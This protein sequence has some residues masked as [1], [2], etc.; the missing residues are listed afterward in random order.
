MNFSL[1]FQTLEVNQ[2]PGKKISIVPEFCEKVC[3]SDLCG[4]GSVIYL[5]HIA[6]YSTLNE[7][8]S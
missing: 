1:L 6:F 2:I 7:S 5:D 4:R 8:G 3:H